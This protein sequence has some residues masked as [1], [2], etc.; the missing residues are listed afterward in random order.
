MALDTCF[1]PHFEVIDGKW[2]LNYKPKEK[3]PVEKFLEGQGRFR[4]LF[5]PDNKHVIES[6]Q[7]EVDKRWEELLVRCGEEK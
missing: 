7:A 6:L 1:W 2:T 5:R 3:L 4:H